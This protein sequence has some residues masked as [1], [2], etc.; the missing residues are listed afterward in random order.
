MF[1]LMQSANLVVAIVFR[2][3]AGEDCSDRPRNQLESNRSLFMATTAY[4]IYSHYDP[5]QREHLERET[6]QRPPEGQGIDS[7]DIWDAEAQIAFA[8]RQLPPP[9]FVPAVGDSSTSLPKPISRPP[10]ASDVAVWYRSLTE[11]TNG[12]RPISTPST[13]APALPQPV[14]RPPERRS[15]NNWFI[16]NAITSESEPAPIT[17]APSTLADILARDPPPLPHEKQYKPPVFLALGPANR[18]FAMLQNSGWSE[19]EPLGPD[20]SRRPPAHPDMIA[21]LGGNSKVKGEVLDVPIGKQ[22]GNFVPAEII[23]LTVSDSESEE[24][25]AE[26]VVDEDIDNAPVSIGEHAEGSSRKALITPIATVLKSDRLGI[27]LKAK[28]VGPYKASQKRITHNAAAMAAHVKA[29][30]AL[31]KQKK[32]MGRG[33]RGFARQR[34]AEETN[35]R[36]LLAYM[37]T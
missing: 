25:E 17:A 18:G 36:D 2:R 14:P 32:L 27:G 13:S 9:R 19:G 6:G 28:T 15:K 24:S 1:G 22:K 29:A 26:E 8:K 35:R 21:T 12:S 30:E 5:A 7:A 10:P 34:K 11:T 20:V 3:I 16:M 4:T 33:H 37:N 23:D 31:K